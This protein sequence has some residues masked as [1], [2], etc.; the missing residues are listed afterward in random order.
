MINHNPLQKNFARVKFGLLFGLVTGSLLTTGWRIDP[1]SWLIKEYKNYR[2]FYKKP[3]RK[4]K[5]D[6]T[7]LIDN[8]IQSVQRFF[9]SG[10]KKKFDIYIH[11]DRQSLNEQWQ[12]DWKQPGFKSECWMVASGVANKLDIISPEVWVNQ[13]C[14]HDYKDKA[15]T[16]QLITHE[17]VHV[18]HGQLNPSPDFS[19][20]DHIDWFVEG[21]ATYASGQMD[22]SR[23]SEIKKEISEKMIPGSLDNFWTGES[24]YALSGSAVMYIDHIYGRDKLIQLLRFTKKTEILNSLN[25]TE[26][27]F[28]S[29]WKDFLAAFN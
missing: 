14:E 6:Y 24:K 23:I 20:T 9:H 16:Q 15:H 27:K 13:A 7:P 29:G 17:L 8:G 25:T 22:S 18:Y 21:V 28:L 11:P 4:N 2:L 10:Y 19:E 1:N 3:D 26:E 5:N 12:K